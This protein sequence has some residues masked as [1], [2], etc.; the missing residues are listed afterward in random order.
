[1]T[2]Q[3]T[4]GII[5]TCIHCKTEFLCNGHC[6]VTEDYEGRKLFCHCPKCIPDWDHDDDCECSKCIK[7]SKIEPPKDECERRMMRVA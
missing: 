1:M 4:T 3:E 2:L 7:G 6:G 5:Q